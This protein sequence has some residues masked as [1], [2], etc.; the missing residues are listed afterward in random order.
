MPDDGRSRA[1]RAHAFGRAAPPT[2]RR[3]VQPR[4]DAARYTRPVAGGRRRDDPRCA[5]RITRA[6][7]ANCGRAS[8]APCRRHDTGRRDAARGNGPRVSPLLGQRACP[9]PSACDTAPLETR[10]RA[11]PR[12]H[13]R[14]KPLDHEPSGRHDHGPAPRRV[15]PPSTAT[16]CQA[17]SW[18]FVSRTAHSRLHGRPEA[19]LDHPRTSLTAACPRVRNRSPNCTRVAEIEPQFTSSRA[20]SSAPSRA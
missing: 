6:S 15:R 8:D 4:V 19:L 7:S 17:R 13:V 2:R 14:G 10:H 1:R 9:A 11:A 16:G 12:N 18:S 20:P 3:P 5:D